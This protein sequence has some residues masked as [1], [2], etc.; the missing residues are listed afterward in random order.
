[1]WGRDFLDFQVHYWLS[2]NQEVLLGAVARK[3]QENAANGPSCPTTA[4][5]MVGKSFDGFCKNSTSHKAHVPFLVLEEEY[6]SSYVSSAFQISCKYTSLAECNSQP[7]S[8]MPCSCQSSNPTIHRR[9]TKRCI[10][11]VQSKQTGVP[12]VAQQKRIRLG[13]MRLRV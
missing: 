3:L 6:R 1:M 10:L 2:E 11:V 5:W 4:G 12:F 7:G 9:T 13:S 8:W